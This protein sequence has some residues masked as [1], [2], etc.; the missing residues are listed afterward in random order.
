V[1]VT[2]DWRTALR[3]PHR[4]PALN[5]A[6]GLSAERIAGPE[7]DYAKVVGTEQVWDNL[8]LVNEARE[9]RRNTIYGQSPT[10]QPRPSVR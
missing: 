7:P 4:I 6:Y 8:E 9:H 1:F 5:E 10:S 2:G 3:T